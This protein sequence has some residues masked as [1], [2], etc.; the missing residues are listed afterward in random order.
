M[1]KD[2]SDNASPEQIIAAA[3]AVGRHLATPSAIITG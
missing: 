3:R 2:A 1:A